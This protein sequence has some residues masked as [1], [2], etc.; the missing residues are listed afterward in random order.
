MAKDEDMNPLER[1]EAGVLRS[2][3]KGKKVSAAAN[4]FGVDLPASVSKALNNAAAVEVTT[5]SKWCLTESPEGEPTRVRAFA[6]LP[7]LLRYF[8]S[9]DDTEMVVSVTY[10]VPC[11][12]TKKID[13]VRYL[14]VGDEFAAKISEIPGSTIEVSEVAD[15]PTQSDGWLGDCFY[16]LGGDD[17]DCD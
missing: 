12:F 10:G 3:H 4:F 17:D 8:A 2:A 11:T 9:I 7:D 5:R 1:I 6:R 15:W 14:L 16:E 13:G